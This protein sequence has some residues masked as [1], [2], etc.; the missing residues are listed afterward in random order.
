MLNAGP[1]LLE[2]CR[3]VAQDYEAYKNAMGTYWIALARTQEWPNPA[4]PALRYPY[5]FRIPGIHTFVYV[6]Y[7]RPC[8]YHPQGAIV[9]SK[10]NYQPLDTTNYY[11]LVLAKAHFLYYEAEVAGALLSQEHSYRI[12]ALCRNVTFRGQAVTAR[13]GTAI[14]PERV[15]SYEVLWVGST[16]AVYPNSATLHRIQIVRAY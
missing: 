13:A 2:R 16:Q 6:H 4:E 3:R 11:E 9:T 8:Y 1:T 14:L 5:T 10:H 12:I 7:C 15:R